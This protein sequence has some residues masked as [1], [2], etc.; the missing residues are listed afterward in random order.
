MS[1]LVLIWFLAL[2]V[3]GAYHGHRRWGYGGG[4]GMGI[5]TVLR[6]LLAVNA[7]GVHH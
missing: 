6:R 3:G 2:G 4:A 5:G 1:M 7:L